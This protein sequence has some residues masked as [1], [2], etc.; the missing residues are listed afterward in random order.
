MIKRF[1]QAFILYLNMNTL[2]LES[3]EIGN[4]VPHVLRGQ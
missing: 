2:D 3:S 1:H 4:T